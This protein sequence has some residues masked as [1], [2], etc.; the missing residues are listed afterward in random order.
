[1]R[2]T[3]LIKTIQPDQSNPKESE[4]KEDGFSAKTLEE[5]PISLSK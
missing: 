5:K 3:L 2:I 1:M 4:Q